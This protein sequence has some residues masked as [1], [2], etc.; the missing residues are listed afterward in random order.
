VT[1]LAGE[2]RRALPPEEFREVIGH[3]ASGVT[4]I[5]TTRDRTPFG[6]TASAVSS[7]SL[8]PPMLLICMNRASSTGQAV[9]ETGRFA[10]NILSEDHPD[11][12]ERFAKK[13]HD[14]FKGI[15][16][17]DGEWSVPLLRDALATLEC[18]VVEDVTAGTH[19][20]FLAEV[21][22]ASAQ[23]G[24]P[25]AYF[26]GQFG[27]LHLAQDETAFC[28]LRDRVLSR[29]I[30]IGTPLSIDHLA[31]VLE[32][33]RGSVY[34][35][36]IR[37]TVEGLL[38][39]DP[40]GA[41]I[42]TPLT[43]AALRAGLSA[44]CAIELGVASMTVGRLEPERLGQLRA[45]RDATQP[46]PNEAFDMRE[47]VSRY[48]SFHDHVVRLAGSRPLLDAYRRVNVPMMITTLTGPRAATDRAERPAAEGAFR[49]HVE[50]VEAYERG[51]L[52]CA[53]RTIVHHME[54]SF[55]FAA[56]YFDAP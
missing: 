21:E 32:L 40:E 28:E 12:A 11:I 56:R 6:T 50:L 49:H 17:A 27:R 23:P 1:R 47:Y 51:D 52:E 10:V 39:R 3:F 41:F 14:K 18:R 26:R 20:V 4:V 46:A 16:V 53:R 5:T 7:L 9:A 30:E 29:E 22:R 43:L 44:R 13:G 45:L 42:V 38:T 19:T 54:R 15:R 36:L 24:A 37:L 48:S 55:E 8:E 2:A 34:H 31:A 35:A 25:L 33:P